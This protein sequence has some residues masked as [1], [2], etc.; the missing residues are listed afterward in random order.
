MKFAKVFL[1]S[2]LLLPIFSSMGQ[3]VINSKDSLYQLILKAG[4]DS[5]KAKYN[6]RLGEIFLKESNY[7]NAS[8]HFYQALDYYEKL[9][10][11]IKAADC[12]RNIAV[13]K[14]YQKDFSSSQQLNK[15]AIAVYTAHRLFTEAGNAYKGLGD[16]AL[17][18]EDTPTCK[19]NYQIALD[20]FNKQKDSIGIASIY[21]NLAIANWSQSALKID[22]LLKAN[23]IWE[24]KAPNHILALINLGN[25][26]VHYLDKVRFNHVNKS[27]GLTAEQKGD[28][29]KGEYYLKKAV[30][31]AQINNDIDNSAYF[32]GVLAEL[33][34]EKGDF[35]SAYKN[36][37]RFYDV[38]D[39][40][41]SQDSKN[42]LAKIESQKEID[43]KNNE[44]AI[45]QLTIANQRKQN[46]L[47]LLA[48]ALIAVIGAIIWRQSMLRKK[49]NQQLHHLNTQLDS[50]NK[51]KA[52][53]FAILAHDLRAPI[54]NLVNFLSL[55]KA[56]N[57]LLTKDQIAHHE[58]KVEHAAS[59]LLANM[60]SMLLWSK[61]QME[62]FTLENKEVNIGEQFEKLKGAFSLIENVSFDFQ[63]KEDVT[64]RTDEHFLYSILHNLTANAVDALK[65][66]ENG[67][68]FWEAT[69]SANTCYITITDN[70]P[71][72][73][74]E[75]TG[76]ST[77]GSNSIGHKKGFG[78]HLI[79]D[80]SSAIGAQIEVQSTKGKTVFKISVPELNAQNIARKKEG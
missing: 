8:K 65:H 58:R 71:G 40:I 79:K 6:Y 51:F 69:K 67:R 76:F 26:G 75:T 29:S 11:E 56:D 9:N 24:K 23:A 31:I 38:Y 78:L 44:L 37:H 19:K 46:F 53:L 80:M 21:S 55:K 32:T 47:S 35:E 64:I 54:A 34:A 39:S 30:S 33:Q 41:Y 12:K 62:N 1:L 68:I 17:L 10:N 57:G 66:Q 15:E 13:L 16:A 7:E 52:K 4:E 18:Q 45:Q 22:N 48:L 74:K 60:E 50:A 61:S 72:L 2:I 73:D 14:F 42:K 43:R 5:T 77:E 25:I 20:Y 3:T 70:G 63:S 36:F 28:L 59:S 27:S 49:T